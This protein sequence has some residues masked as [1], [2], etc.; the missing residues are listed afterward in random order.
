MVQKDPLATK[1]MTVLEVSREGQDDMELME[2]LDKRVLM[3]VM[4]LAENMEYLVH[5]V[6]LDSP[7]LQV[8]Q[9]AEGA[10]AELANLGSEG[11]QANRFVI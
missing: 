7:D 9:G 5:Q 4:V 8:I 2:I 10:E 11:Y 3:D 6:V 1:A